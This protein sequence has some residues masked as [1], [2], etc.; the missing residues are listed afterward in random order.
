M[1]FRIGTGIDIHPW[2]EGRKF[3]LGGIKIPYSS[4]LVGHSDGDVLIHAL[5]DALLGSMGLGDIGEHFPPSDEK[6]K[7]ISSL[8]LLRKVMK[9]VREKKG[10]VI[11]V[12]ATI[13]LEEPKITPYKEK[14]KWVLSKE[15]RIPPSC[16]NIKATTCE[17]LGFVGRNEG[18]VSIVSVMVKKND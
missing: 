7:G 17:G 5:M 18:V 12:D 16:I 9:L 15:L 3:C 1:E 11:N 4:G 8:R 10:E 6:L 13:M 2:G 14:I